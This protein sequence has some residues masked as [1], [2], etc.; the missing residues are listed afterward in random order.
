MNYLNKQ[1]VLFGALLLL[2][3]CFSA[4]VKDGCNIPDPSI[5]SASSEDDYMRSYFQTNNITDLTKHPSGVYYKLN[6]PGSG[7][8]G[9]G[10]CNTIFFNY[11]AYKF[12]SGVAF[13]SY[14]QPGGTG[15]LLGNLIIGVK[16]VLPLV[17]PGGS[18]TMYIPPSLAYGNE[19][20]K[21]QNGNV[22]LPANSYIKFDISLVSFQ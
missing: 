14:D 11:Y 2:C 20:I 3:S 8:Q 9:P 10:L 4:C 22:I 19:T 7:T 12:G 21:D 1:A 18:I 15:F 17:K 13:D 5:T 16:K 6:T